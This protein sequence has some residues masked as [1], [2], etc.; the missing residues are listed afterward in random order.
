VLKEIILQPSSAQKPP[1]AAGIAALANLG[2]LA[3]YLIQRKN[4]YYHIYPAPLFAVV[5][6]G[7]LVFRLVPRVYAETQPLPR[8][9]ERRLF[10]ARTPDRSALFRWIRNP[11][12]TMSDLVWAERSNMGKEPR[13]STSARHFGDRDHVSSSRTQ[14]SRHLGRPIS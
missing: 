6:A 8:P 13:S 7:I 9:S 3:A 5:S 10:D 4:W 11:H 14:H 2:Y 12:P 1:V